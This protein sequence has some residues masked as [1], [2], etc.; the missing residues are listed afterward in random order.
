MTATKAIYVCG[1]CQRI[2][3][4]WFEYEPSPWDSRECP[5]CGTLNKIESVEHVAITV[6]T[7]QR[8]GGEN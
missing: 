6:S 7:K 1:N 5:D 3:N 2:F 4:M 8:E